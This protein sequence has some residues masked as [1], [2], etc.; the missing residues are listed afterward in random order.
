MVNSEKDDVMLINYYLNAYHMDEMGCNE[1]TELNNA[2]E[3]SFSMENT[4]LSGL[5]PNMT[6]LNVS[7]RD[8]ES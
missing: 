1:F 2:G 7:A 6:P 5:S 8:T 3:L 4:H